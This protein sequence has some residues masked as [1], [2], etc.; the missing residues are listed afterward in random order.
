MINHTR[1]EKWREYYHE[2]N[3]DRELPHEDMVCYGCGEAFEY[4]NTITMINNDPYCS[5]D[6]FMGIQEIDESWSTLDTPAPEELA[7]DF[8]ENCTKQQ[9]LAIL[10]FCNL[11]DIEFK[12]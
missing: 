2:Q 1:N 5:E 10:H 3:L 8:F 4:N 6:C 11:M 7:K 9:R 12:I